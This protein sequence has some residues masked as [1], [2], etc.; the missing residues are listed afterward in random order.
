MRLY[1]AANFRD[2]FGDDLRERHVVREFLKQF[3]MIS[4]ADETVGWGLYRNY[5]KHMKLNGRCLA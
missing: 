1:L 3:R 2:F 5:M 4:K